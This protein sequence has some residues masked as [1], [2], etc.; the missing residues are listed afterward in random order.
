MAT[1][2][3]PDVKTPLCR[4]AFT[5]TLFVPQVR[6]NGTKQ[7]GCTL[8]FP[9]STPLADLK[10]A[11]THAATHTWGKD[12][13]TLV[14]NSVLH[15]PFLDGDGPQGAS[16]KT[17]KRHPGF[18]DHVFL[19][20]VSGE[21]YPPQIFDRRMQR[22]SDPRDLY[23]GCYGYAMVNAFSLED[24]NGRGVS[25]GVSMVQFVKEGERLGGGIP[26]Q[27]AFFA[28]LEDD[29]TGE[30]DDAGAASLFD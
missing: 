29:N 6:D 27:S 22:L 25:F 28:P 5:K 30:R 9:K 7:Y 15:S 21:D 19:R 23:S 12:A 24:Q 8:L 20:V 26:D 10:S 3:S 1:E 2:R 4:L 18:A 11:V 17:G 14:K 16:K 13:L